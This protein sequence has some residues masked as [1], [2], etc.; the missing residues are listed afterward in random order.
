MDQFSRASALHARIEDL[1]EQANTRQLRLKEKLEFL[2]AWD[3]LK[4]IVLISEP[5][6]DD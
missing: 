6:D 3:E 5:R 1:R 2:S 4:T